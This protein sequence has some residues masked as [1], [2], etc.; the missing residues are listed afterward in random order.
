M[1]TTQASLENTPCPFNIHA[2]AMCVTLYSSALA[3]FPFST[4]CVY[5]WET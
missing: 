1:V 5:M 3:A 4:E 2:S